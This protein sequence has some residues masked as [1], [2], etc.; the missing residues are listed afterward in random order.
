[1]D[2]SQYK[3]YVLTLLFVK[4]VS[5]KAKTDHG[6]LIEVPEGCSFD[7]MVALPR[8]A[9]IG[10]RI[11]QII[12]ELANANDLRGV[13]DVTSFNDDAKLGKGKEMIDRLSK[14]IAIFDS[15]DFRASRADGDDL[16]GDAYEYL[17]RHFAAESGKSKGQ[18]Y[19]PSE[20]SRILAKVVGI[21]GSARQDQTIYDPTCGSG[22]LLLK[23]ANEAPHG[24]TIY[25]QEKDLATW[26]LSRMNMVLHGNETAEIENGDVITSPGFTQDGNLKQHDFIVANPPFSVKAWSNGIN[27]AND[28]Y[29]RFEIGIPPEKNGDYAFLL[30]AIKS[31]KSQGKASVILPHG[32]LFRGGAEEKIRRSLLQRGLIKGIIGLPSNLFYG[33]G[34]PACIVVIDKEGAEERDSVFLINAS[35]G[36]KKDG[37]KNRLREQDLHKIVDVFRSRTE[38]DGFSRAVSIEEIANEANDFSLNL[39]RYIDASEPEDLQN[40]D[41]HLN[42]GIPDHDLDLLS[43]YWDAFPS[44][45][46]QLFEPARPGYSNA[47]VSADEVQATVDANSDVQGFSRTVEEKVI[48]WWRS[49]QETLD[50]IDKGTLPGPIIQELSEDL[51]QRFSDFPLLDPYDIYEQLMNYWAETM[52]DDIYLVSAEGWFEAAQPR[53]L[54][55]IGQTDKGKPKYEDPDLSYGSGK[56]TRKFKMD[57]LPPE[58]IVEQFF[59]DDGQKLTE[60]EVS[61]DQASQAIEDYTSEHA[62]EDGLLGEVIGEDGKIA[63]KAVTDRIKQIAG[64]DAFE[65]ELKALKNYLGLLEAEAAAKKAVKAAEVAL[66]E[67]TVAKYAKFDTELLKQSTMSGKWRQSIYGMVMG[68]SSASVGLLARRLAQ[69]GD[70]YDDPLPDVVA[71]AELI[72]ARVSVHLQDLLTAGVADGSS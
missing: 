58:I 32:V 23:A 34:I 3:D 38:I 26:A 10:D 65:D 37:P 12:A 6:S 36:Y 15:L 7:D 22:S 39:P 64:Q 63:K 71:R 2:A 61:R 48:E 11:D 60:L 29:G 21:G 43:D 1:M 28:E 24:L 68:I 54:R 19:T 45:R 8:D 5:D 69:L 49:H 44:L 17:M 13:I 20:V 50:G 33:T 66:G 52:R 53:A 9:E 4:Y 30:H 41:A 31:L 25:G 70:R 47:K 42:G 35:E 46:D 27:P 16:L 40:L 14:L 72:E 18:F 67:K 59:A 51:L 62:V 55:E 56:S 57:L